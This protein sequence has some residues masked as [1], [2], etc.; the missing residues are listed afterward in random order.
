ML[1][2]AETQAEQR[3]SG[4]P[5]VPNTSL[6]ARLATETSAF[7]H[8]PGPEHWVMRAEWK[9]ASQLISSQHGQLPSLRACR[10]HCSKQKERADAESHQIRP[11]LHDKRATTMLANRNDYGS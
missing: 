2:E 8:E 4:I 6:T 11:R 3:S 1:A 5:P 10:R 9:G 7:Y